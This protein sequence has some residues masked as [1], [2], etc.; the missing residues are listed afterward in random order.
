MPVFPTNHWNAQVPEPIES[1]QE[2]IDLAVPAAGT[3]EPVPG[4][5]A[6][7][8]VFQRKMD[9]NYLGTVNVLMPLVPRMRARGMYG[10][11]RDHGLSGRLPPPQST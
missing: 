11:G 4:E 7:P 10:P 1:A 6:N 2:P 3:Y 8:S 5:I 9:V